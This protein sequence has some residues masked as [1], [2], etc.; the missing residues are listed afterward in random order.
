MNNTNRTELSTLGEFGL[1]RHLTKSFQSRQPTT[2]KAVGDDAAVIDASENYL[3]ITNDLLIEGIHFDMVYTPL[4]H[5]G[6]KSVVVNLSDIAAMNGKPQQVLVSLSVSNRYSVE[7]LEELYTGIRLACE[8]YHVD[9]VGGDTTTSRQGLFL[10]VTAIGMVEKNRVC[11]RDTARINDL[12]C[13]S[14][15]LGAAYMGLLV[16]E[17]EKQVFK[18]DP[19]MQPDLSGFNYILQRQ[20]RPEARFDVLE[21]LRNAGIQP[22][23]MIDISD[24]LASEI[25]H[26]CTGSKTGCQLFEDKIPIDP[27]TALAAEEFGIQAITAAMNGGEDYEL[28]FTIPLSDYD[29][30][31]SIKDI[32]VIGHITAE[33]Q[34]INLI[35]LDGTA[36][37]VQ[38]QG[39]QH[40]MK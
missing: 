11:Y 19:T 9:L 13:V 40:F 26:I 14:G 12:V 27:A 32:T 6:Y 30:I 36:V 35:A 21:F 24:G 8:H 23:S 34:G 10:S 18:A 5:L 28:L 39:W 1:I 37:P 25:L 2:V 17:R 33:S 7:A 20:L 3:L 29:K 22:T 15:N 4:K 16:L 38:A 31:T